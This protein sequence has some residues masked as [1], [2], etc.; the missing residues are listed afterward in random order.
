MIE[1]IFVFSNESDLWAVCEQ[2]LRESV[3]WVSGTGRRPGVFFSGGGTFI[4]FYERFGDI[5][6]DV[7]PTDD[8]MVPEGTVSDTTSM[9]RREWHR[10]VVEPGSRVVGVE[11]LGSAQ[12]TAA[13][14]EQKIRTWTERG[15]VFAAA[16]LG[17][18]SDGHTASLF[19]GQRDMWETTQSWVVATEGEQEPL[20]PRVTVTPELLRT[21]PRHIYVLMGSGKLPIANAWLK[22]RKVLPCELVQPAE[23]R[24]VLLDSVA[25]R[26]LDPKTYTRY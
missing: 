11:R 10:K 17:V 3:D 16:L 4:P 19:P 15:G 14:Y 2:K 8:R 6:G 7:F 25:A 23:E 26:D 21:V 20:V 1:H 5:Q 13:Q 9:L 24:Y 22:E 12:E 18:G